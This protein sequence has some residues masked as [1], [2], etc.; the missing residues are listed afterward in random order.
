M[1][2]RIDKEIERRLATVRLPIDLEARVRGPPALVLDG[3]RPDLGLKIARRPARQ[4]RPLSQLAGE[5]NRA[6][7]GVVAFEELVAAQA[8]APLDARGRGR[9]IVLT[10]KRLEQP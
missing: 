9:E 2:D 3:P 1:G 10:L 4:R 7:C 5:D 8:A 6:I